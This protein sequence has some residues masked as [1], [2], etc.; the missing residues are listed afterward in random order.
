MRNKAGARRGPDGAGAW[1]RNTGIAGK[2]GEWEG[3]ATGCLCVKM[4]RHVFLEV[5]ENTTT[6]MYFLMMP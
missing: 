4:I 6:S 1:R 3:V 2:D 5:F